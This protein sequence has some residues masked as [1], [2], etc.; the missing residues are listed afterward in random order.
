MAYAHVSQREEE[1][2]K[3]RADSQRRTGLAS[4]A[5]ADVLITA[6]LVYYLKQSQSHFVTTNK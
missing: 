2:V 4:A 6:S 1:G 5:F 3:G